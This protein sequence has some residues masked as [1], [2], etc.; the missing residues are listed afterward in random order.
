MTTRSTERSLGICSRAVAFS[1]S[2]ALS[3]L[4]HCTPSFGPPTPS[5]IQLPFFSELEKEK[6]TGALNLRAGGPLAGRAGRGDSGRR[7]VLPGEVRPPRGV[8]RGRGAAEAGDAGLTRSLRLARS[9]P[10]ASLARPL[11]GSDSHY[12][13]IPIWHPLCAHA[14]HSFLRLLFCVCAQRTPS[15]TFSKCLRHVLSQLAG[16]TLRPFPHPRWDAPAPGLIATAPPHTHS[17][18]QTP[19]V[20]TAPSPSDSPRFFPLAPSIPDLQK[21]PI[22]GAF[23]NPSAGKS[24]QT[25]QLTGHFRFCRFT[26]PPWSKCTNLRFIRGRLVASGKKFN[27]LR[28]PGPAHCAPPRS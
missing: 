25:P 18:I 21:V 4:S 27:P 28:D 11:R 10:A 14:R 23:A 17:H 5:P 20:P 7:G 2:P 13:L 22:T 9:P 12:S 16:G 3:L 26:N 8:D 1:P 24:R 19:H 15:T 6:L